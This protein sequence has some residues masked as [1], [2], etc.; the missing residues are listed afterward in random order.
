MDQKTV[1]LANN[2]DRWIKLL[3]SV[4]FFSI[5]EDAEVRDILETGK[6]RKFRSDDHIV[7]EEDA[8]FPFF[9]IVQGDVKV[10][11]SHSTSRRK[12]KLAE[13]HTGDCFGEIAMIAGGKRSAEVIAEGDCYVFAIDGAELEKLAVPLKTKFYKRICLHMA[14]KFKKL[15]E[16]VVDFS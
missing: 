7:R 1:E 10:V 14:Y 3:K 5:F 16:T 2:P 9:V 11:K 12:V 13:L 8:E 15:S 4:D 6:M